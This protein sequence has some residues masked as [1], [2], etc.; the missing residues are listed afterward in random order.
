MPE[1]AGRNLAEIRLLASE[2]EIKEAFEWVPNME[3]IKQLNKEGKTGKFYAV[4]ALHEGITDPNNVGHGRRQYTEEE[5]KM[6]ARTLIGRYL[7]INHKDS[8]KSGNNVVVDAE[9]DAKEKVIEAIVY[10]EDPWAQQEISNGDIQH[11][12]VQGPP[13]RAAQILN[14]GTLVPAG[15][16]FDGLAL[17]TKENLPGDPK[18]SIRLIEINKKSSLNQ[19]HRSTSRMPI[20]QNSIKVFENL[21]AFLAALETIGDMPPE[22]KMQLASLAKQLYG[23]VGEIKKLAESL[24]RVPSNLNE[25][26]Q[27]IGK[28]LEDIKNLGSGQQ[29]LLKQINELRT[30]AK[31]AQLPVTQETLSEGAKKVAL[32]IAVRNTPLKDIVEMTGTSPE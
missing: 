28:I 18:S 29:D 23:Q 13:P 21:D 10:I 24:R 11:V 8:L 12:S 30:S 31:S 7:N 3:R 5:L 16:F 22:I 26:M 6:A 14:D 9:W 25:Q 32:Q 2:K 1:G 4:K 15:I 27:Q 20:D 17:V 19:E